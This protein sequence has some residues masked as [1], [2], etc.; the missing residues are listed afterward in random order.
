MQ[1]DNNIMI[2]VV[3]MSFPVVNTTVKV[4]EVWDF[5]CES[6][7]ASTKVLHTLPLVRIK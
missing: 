2:S 4:A 1:Y 7:R 5:L 3:P 6:H